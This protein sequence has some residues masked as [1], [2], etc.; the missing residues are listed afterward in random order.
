MLKKDVMMALW[1]FFG[2]AIVFG[3]TGMQMES[4][5]GGVEMKSELNAVQCMLLPLA[6]DHLV[7]RNWVD[8]TREQGM[9]TGKRGTG[10]YGKTLALAVKERVLKPYGDKLLELEKGLDVMSY[11]QL[12]LKL[13]SYCLVFHHIRALLESIDD[14]GL[15]GPQLLAR[16]FEC[17]NTGIPELRELYLQLFERVNQVFYRQLIPWMN[18]GTLNDPHGEFFIQRAEQEQQQQEDQVNWNLYRVEPSLVPAHVSMVDVENVLF[19]GKCASVLTL[20]GGGGVDG[21]ALR[22]GSFHI[23]IKEARYSASRQLLGSL[24]KEGLQSQL[25]FVKQFLLMGNGNVFSKFISLCSS[26]FSR[27]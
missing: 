15:F 7:V 25:L 21:D 22:A 19:V 11:T 4:P 5:G 3:D 1:G 12:R 8:E 27:R 26:M 14:E 10:M 9:G 23:V 2:D 13:D 18:K 6:N 24:W 20:D 16:L 17:C